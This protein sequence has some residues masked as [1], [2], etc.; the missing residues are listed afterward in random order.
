MNDKKKSFYDKLF[1][2]GKQTDKEYVPTI[3]I[4]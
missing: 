3:N 2:E 4:K 1:T